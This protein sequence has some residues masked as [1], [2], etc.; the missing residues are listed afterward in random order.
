MLLKAGL[1]ALTSSFV[2]SLIFSI[3]SADIT[4]D[5]KSLMTHSY[6]N[7]PSYQSQELVREGLHQIIKDN[8]LPYV[9]DF[10][11]SEDRTLEE[12]VVLVKEVENSNIAISEV[13]T[14]LESV[15]RH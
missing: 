15:L 12:V 1:V 13:E 4:R 14:V 9:I 6:Q 5:L 7:P 11:D 10:Q 2:L 3:Y 8:E